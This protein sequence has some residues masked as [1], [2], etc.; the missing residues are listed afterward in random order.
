M[1]EIADEAGINKALLHYYFR[2][3][4][5]L[6]EGVFREAFFK[7]FPNILSLLKQD[8]P[9]GHK[10][11]LAPIAKGADKEWSVREGDAHGA[12]D[13]E[14]VEAEQAGPKGRMGLPRARI[15]DRLGDPGAPISIT[16]ELEDG[17]RPVLEGGK[18]L[19]M[20]IGFLG[21]TADRTHGDN[22]GGRSGTRQRVR[23]R[24]ECA[25]DRNGP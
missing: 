16:G 21:D 20:G 10:V 25:S 14:L 19:T 22:P 7:L 8:I 3:K 2:S 9:F 11:A 24:Q 6:F 18:R 1:Q 5:K 15:V 23:S 13:G 17:R 12:K 4:D